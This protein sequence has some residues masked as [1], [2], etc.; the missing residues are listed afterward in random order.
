MTGS[1]C[2]HEYHDSGNPWMS[3]TSGPDPSSTQW[4]LV[5]RAFTTWCLMGQRLCEGVTGDCS[6]CGSRPC[7]AAVTPPSRPLTRLLGQVPELRGVVVLG[8]VLDGRR[9]GGRDLRLPRPHVV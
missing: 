9:G 1:W 2:R 5:P 6:G 8:Q 4:I 3:R 7:H